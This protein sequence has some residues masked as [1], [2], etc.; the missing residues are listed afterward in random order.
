MFID[1]AYHTN[2]KDY[3]EYNEFN[4]LR[5][6]IYDYNYI[7]KPYDEYKSFYDS[8]GL[9]QADYKVLISKTLDVS[10]KLNSQTYDKIIEYGK[11]IYKINIFDRIYKGITQSFE[12][13]TNTIVKF[14]VMFF[15]LVLG[16]AWYIETKIKGF[17]FN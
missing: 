12:G 7:P 15:V 4:E 17:F 14:E 8:L 13:L 1:N 3:K 5:S 2:R 9:T 6:E 10:D 11:G 16:I